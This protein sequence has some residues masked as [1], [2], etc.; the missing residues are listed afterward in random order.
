[1]PENNGNAPQEG[2]EDINN[3]P[4]NGATTTPKNNGANN[5]D[6]QN[7]DGSV[8]LS[9]EQWEQ[10][11]QHP[12]FKSLLEKS[13]KLDEIEQEKRQAEEERMKKQGEFE[14]LVSE[15]QKEATEWKTRYETA[16]IENAIVTA[17]SGKNVVD[18]E[19]VLRLIDKDNLEI[20]DDGKVKNVEAVVGDLLKAKPYLVGEQAP[21]NVGASD[22]ANNGDDGKKIWTESEIRE[23]MR[24]REWFKKNESEV[25]KAFSEGRV[26][27]G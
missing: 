4:D 11:F 2:G 18:V 25:K 19:A 13:K 7:Q 9:K 10:A 21:Q 23:K 8:E 6:G 24:D 17:A 15:K 16:V 1:M 27:K 22:N 26:R 14:K 20:G 12:R 5:D 3:T